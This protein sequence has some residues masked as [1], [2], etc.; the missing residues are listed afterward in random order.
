MFITL[1]NVLTASYVYIEDI[2]NSLHYEL[3]RLSFFFTISVSSL[4]T[5]E[6]P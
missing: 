5:L 6:T 1:L 4:K 2:L 3:H